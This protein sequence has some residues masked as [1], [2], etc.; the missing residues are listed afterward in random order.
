VSEMLKFYG[1]RE[2][3][4]GVSPDPRF[5]YPSVQHREAMAS[6][7]FGIENQVGFAALIAEPG[8]GKTTLLFDILLRYREQAST[9]FVFNTQ[10]SGPELLRQVVLELQI[11]GGDSEPDPIRLHQLF[12]SYVAD[13]LRTKPV[14]III[15]EAQN[16]ENSALE[17]LR[18][19]SNFEAADRKLL[20]IILAGQPRLAGKLRNPSL[21]QLLQRITTISRLERFSPAQMEECIAF[22]LRV[23]GYTGPPLFSY[24]AMAKIKTASRGVPR[25]INR[26]CI[27]A[28][29]LGFALRHKQ[30]GVAVIE[31]VLSDLNLEP[32]AETPEE[33]QEESQLAEIEPKVLRTAVEPKVSNASA[34]QRIIA[35]LP[36]EPWH[37]SVRIEQFGFSTCSYFEPEPKAV[38]APPVGKKKQLTAA[39][40][41]EQHKTPRFS[42]GTDTA[43]C[44]ALVIAFVLVGLTC[45]MHLLPRSIAASDRLRPVQVLSPPQTAV[46]KTE[47][48]D[49]ST[50]VQATTRNSTIDTRGDMSGTRKTHPVSEPGAM[51]RPD[52][53]LDSRDTRSA[54]D[55]VVLQ[56]ARPKPAERS[57]RSFAI[58]IGRAPSKQNT[59]Q[60]ASLG[61]MARPGVPSDSR[62]PRTAG[63]DRKAVLIRYVGPVYPPQAYLRGD[64]SLK[65]DIAGDGSVQNIRVLRG[66]RVL[67]RAAEDA[68][69]QWR[70]R[71][72]QQNGT[73]VEEK[74]TVVVKYLGG[75]PKTGHE[76]SLQKRPR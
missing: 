71:P 9:A 1:L 56:P 68:V 18:L 67:A 15:D 46:S 32:R 55:P 40:K 21:T 69:R 2:H 8:A 24:E 16:L 72:A 70:Y 22:R 44:G 66:N 75:S 10:C 61:V 31:E 59:V 19:L 58:N 4:F 39:H 62:G 53:S 60:A 33:L 49:T 48:T 7:I 37:S 30:I 73:A 26:I 29:Q 14:V 20:H 64:V 65:I 41:R 42:G 74:R 43:L 34:E 11:P 28:L 63:G 38:A 51:A 23:A 3:P 35:R 27:N 47:T 57:A 6:L 13:H 45:S 36:E 54:S 25:E 50:A 17:T 5:L 12:T 76:R 52:A